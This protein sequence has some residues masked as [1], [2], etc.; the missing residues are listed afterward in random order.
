MNRLPKWPQVAAAFAVIVLAIY[1][2][3]IFW[4][5]W[6]LPGWLFFLSVGEILTIFA[7]S[8]TVNFLESLLVLAMPLGLSLVLPRKWFSD[9]F[10]TRS[11]LVTLSALGY[12]AYLLTQFQSREDYPGGIVRLIPVVFL[13]SLVLAF[14]LGK[15]KIVVKAIDFFAEQATIFLYIFIPVSLVCGAVILVRILF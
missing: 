2:W 14:L 3:T 5:L 10:V 7:Y 6:K 8:M 9:V 13:A 1:S 11:V 15:I 4:F 12:A